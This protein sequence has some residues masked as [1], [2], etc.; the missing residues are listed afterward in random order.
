MIECKTPSI[1]SRDLIP[2][3]CNSHLSNI[4]SIMGRWRAQATLS[5]A[6]YVATRSAAFVW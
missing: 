6:T 2:F 3:T 1:E 5:T 4:F